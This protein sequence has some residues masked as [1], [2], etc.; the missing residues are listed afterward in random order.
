MEGLLDEVEGPLDEVEGLIDEV[1]ELID[2]VERLVVTDCLLA[3]DDTPC[4]YSPLGSNARFLAC[5]LCNWGY[6]SYGRLYLGFRP[7]L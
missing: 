1:E 3:L 5:K 6:V 7:W 4:R 2:V